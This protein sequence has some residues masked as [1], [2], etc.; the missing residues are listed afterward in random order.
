MPE[1][2]KP[3]PPL[4]L[5]LPS[6]VSCLTVMQCSCREIKMWPLTGKTAAHF[7]FRAGMCN[8]RAIK[9]SS[10]HGLFWHGQSLSSF[11]LTQ[12]L[13]LAGGKEFKADGLSP[14]QL[15]F[16]CFTFQNFKMCCGR[17]AKDAVIIPF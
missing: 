17:G 8:G 1:N 5:A 13:I 10:T 9:F 14:H 2:R 12:I 6:V 7:C 15:Q 3:F 16:V 11:L 4:L